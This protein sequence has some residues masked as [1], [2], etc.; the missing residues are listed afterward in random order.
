MYHPRV[1]RSAQQSPTARVILGDGGVPL[2]GCLTQGSQSALERS[3]EGLL[4]TEG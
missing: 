1:L 2:W 3:L 4:H